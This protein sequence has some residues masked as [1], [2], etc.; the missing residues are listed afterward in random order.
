MFTFPIIRSSYAYVF[1]QTCHFVNCCQ[2]QEPTKARK[3]SMSKH[4][5][6]ALQQDMNA[7]NITHRFVTKM[8]SPSTH[9]NHYLGPVLCTISLLRKCCVNWEKDNRVK[10]F[11]KYVDL[12]WTD[13]CRR[14][15]TSEWT[16]FTTSATVLPQWG[17]FVAPPWPQLFRR[18]HYLSFRSLTYCRPDEFNTVIRVS[19]VRFNECQPWPISHQRTPVSSN[20]LDM[21]PRDGN[22]HEIQHGIKVSE[23][24]ILT[25]SSIHLALTMHLVSPMLRYLTKM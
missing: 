12:S 8:S 6:Q 13:H 19:R 20:D 11:D 18:I 22:S 1:C 4:L 25:K 14:S 2:I 15:D 7:V 16:C 21:Q 9:Q 23:C 3:S 17:G 5:R 10:P 24:K